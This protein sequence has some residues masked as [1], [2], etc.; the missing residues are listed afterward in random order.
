MSIRKKLFVPIFAGVLCLSA[1]MPGQAG[2]VPMQPGQQPA[3]QSREVAAAQKMMN[4]V[5]RALQQNRQSSDTLL[6]AAK[7][8][9]ASPEALEMMEKM[10]AGFRETFMG[11]V[12]PKQLI[13]AILSNNQDVS[14]GL[15]ITAPDGSRWTLTP[16]NKPAKQGKPKPHKPGK[17]GM[18]RQAQPMPPAG[19]MPPQGEPQPGMTPPPPPGCPQS[20]MTPPPPPPGGPQ[21]GM[22]PPPPPPS[23]P[24]PGMIPQA[25]GSM[26][27][28]MTPPPNAPRPGMVPP[29]P[30]YQAPGAQQGPAEVIIMEETVSDMPYWPTKDHLGKGGVLDYLERRNAAQGG[31]R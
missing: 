5:V 1:P 13:E 20:G 2:N 19:M 21:P 25:P 14:H 24:R 23:G 8:A 16:M 18:D 28:G 9:G 4:E 15:I 7:A 26:P 29:P 30:G 22:T 17:P 11:A 10:A 27:P 6:Q 3:P 12:S 31:S